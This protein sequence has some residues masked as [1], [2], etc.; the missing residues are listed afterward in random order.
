MCMWLSTTSVRVQAIHDSFDQG[1]SF[2]RSVACFLEPIRIWPLLQKY[3][4]LAWAPKFAHN[5]CMINSTNIQAYEKASHRSRR[6]GADYQPHQEWRHFVVQAAQDMALKRTPYTAG[7]LR[8]PKDN[9]LSERSSSWSER[10]LSSCSL[11]ER[12]HSSCLKSK[13]R[14][15]RR[16]YDGSTPS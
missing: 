3:S 5:P 6:E 11:S 14:S 7:L 13:K 9:R 2:G 1:A 15:E 8:R 12:S 16:Q 4:S 10:T